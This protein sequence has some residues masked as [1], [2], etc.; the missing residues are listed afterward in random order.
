MKINR[1]FSALLVMILVATLF[2]FPANSVQAASPDI[3]ISQIYGGGGNTGAPYL[4]D[5]VELFN[6][7]G[8]T[9]SITGWSI[10]YASASGTGLFSSNVTSLSGSIPSGKYYLVQTR[11]QVGLE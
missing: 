3:V 4:N 10:Q 1:I 9:V 7:S 8:S 2:S 5:Y 6:R 11:P